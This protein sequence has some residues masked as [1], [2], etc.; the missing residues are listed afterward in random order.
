VR[1]GADDLHHR[2]VTAERENRV[3]FAAALACDLSRMTRTLG[4]REIAAHSPTRERLLRLRL[5]S[6][7]SARP[8]VDDEEDAL[9]QKRNVRKMSKPNCFGVGANPR[10]PIPAVHSRALVEGSYDADIPKFSFNL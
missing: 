7:A 1:E 4:Q 8:W 6:G 9:R 10:P 3:V 5:P 2:S